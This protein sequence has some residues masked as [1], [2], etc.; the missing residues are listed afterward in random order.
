MGE[1]IERVTART[2]GADGLFGPDLQRGWDVA[3]QLASFLVA[4]FCS[5]R[6]EIILLGDGPTRL[7]SADFEMVW[8][9]AVGDW[10]KAYGNHLPYPFFLKNCYITRKRLEEFFRER[11]LE[12][13]PDWGAAS[14][15]QSSAPRASGAVTDASSPAVPSTAIEAIV[16]A[17]VAIGSANAVAAKEANELEHIYIPPNLSEPRATRNARWICIAVRFIHEVPAASIADAIRFIEEREIVATPLKRATFATIQK[18]LNGKE[19]EIREKAKKAIA[20]SSR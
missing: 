1:V 6:G 2:V 13:P 12:W 9:A 20:Y 10:G 14:S 3:K 16:S 8:N 18:V 17:P 4:R 19:A 15:S 7:T 11:N 5:N